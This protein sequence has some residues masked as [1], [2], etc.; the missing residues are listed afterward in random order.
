[1]S[2]K[3]EDAAENARKIRTQLQ[4]VENARASRI[5][6]ALGTLG[7]LVMTAAAVYAL[8]HFNH[9]RAVISHVALDDKA[10]SPRSKGT[11]GPGDDAD[12]GGNASQLSTKR[13][14]WW[15]SRPP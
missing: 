14:N 1:M 6:R 11:A 13:R 3:A 8:P 10:T 4:T 9:T 15:G 12:S 7:A 2:Q 5:T